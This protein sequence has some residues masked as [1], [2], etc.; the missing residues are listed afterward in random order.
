MHFTNNDTL[1]SVILGV[2]GDSSSSVLALQ[3]IKTQ[4]RFTL[5]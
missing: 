2:Q 1:A 4:E 3:S 5:S